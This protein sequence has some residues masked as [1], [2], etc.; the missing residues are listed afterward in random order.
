[1]SQPVQD[2]HVDIAIIGGG[3][4][5][6]WLLNRA[7]NAGY[8][9]VLFEQQAL[10]T[11]QTVASQGMI[12]GGVKYTLGGALS[13]ASE[14]I[15]DMPAHWRLCM[16]GK[17]DVDLRGARILSD[18]FYMWSSQGTVSK[19]TTFLAS[20][21]LRGRVDALKKND[22]PPIFHN[23][24]F[25]GSLYK[26]V[27]MVLDVPSLLDILRKPYADRIF[28]IDWQQSQLQK[29]DSGATI[30]SN[31]GNESVRINSQL[32]VLAAGKGNG[33]LLQKLDVKKPAMQLRPL[34]QVMVRHRHHHALYAHCVGTDSKPRLTISS[35]RDGEYTVWYLGGQLAEEGA[36][37]PPD[38]LIERARKEL[39]TL[40]SWLDWTEAEWATLPVE[41]AEP[42]QPGMLRPDNAWL[43]ACEG[44]THCVV[45]WPTKLTLVPNL[46]NLLMDYLT[47]RTIV[48][49]HND[50]IPSGFLQLDT[51]A[52]TPWQHPEWKK[53]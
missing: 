13:G 47:Q 52:P 50:K 7:C 34:Q 16:S 44:L 20:K 17:G 15:A 19:I 21:A 5:G 9:A 42:A 38:I 29:K 1:M 25:K 39:Q 4:A 31:A 24:A 35:H 32:T 51:I 12:H 36:S 40:F 23:A 22:Y 28:A 41:R 37:L 27:D 11:D 45:A 2:I 48:P 8:N 26:L 43:S 49:L 10:G 3:V 53:V 14:S 30:I 6:L 33:E 18:H 46:G